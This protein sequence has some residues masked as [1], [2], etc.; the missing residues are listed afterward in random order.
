MLSVHYVLE[1]VSRDV[2][3]FGK[4]DCPAPDPGVLFGTVIL[5]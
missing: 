4:F 2:E 5:T 3:S 1:H